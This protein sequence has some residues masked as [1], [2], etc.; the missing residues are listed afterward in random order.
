MRDGRLVFP[1]NRDG[2]WTIYT[3][4]ADGSG[5][6][7]A[8]VGLTGLYVAGGEVSEWRDGSGLAFSANDEEG[9][10]LFEL[11]A[12]ATAAKRISPAG[13]P[14]TRPA[15]SPDGRWLAY[16]ARDT[17]GLQVYVRDLPGRKKWP[18]STEGASLVRW[19]PNG[20]ALY[21]LAGDKIMRVARPTQSSLAAPRPTLAA[22]IPGLVYF[23]VAE[24]GRFLV[25]RRLSA[26]P[27]PQLVVI[28]NWRSLLQ[29]L[30][31]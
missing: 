8:V 9:L 3:A 5:A 2:R 28:P 23:D 26:V 6:R 17:G 27:P 29:A 7:Q 21:Y 15:V 11:R 30:A 24:G 10:G 19:A 13:V 25:I 31:K 4:S 16:T 1:S 22:R 12:G 18:V 14:E 20:E